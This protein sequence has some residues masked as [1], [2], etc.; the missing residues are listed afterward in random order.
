MRLFRT[1]SKNKVEILQVGDEP[2]D[3]IFECDLQHEYPINELYSNKKRSYHR[4]LKKL[5]LQDYLKN[6]EIL[7]DSTDEIFVCDLQYEYLIN[8]LYS[9]P[10]N[11]HT[12]AIKQILDDAKTPPKDYNPI[13]RKLYNLA[14]D[15]PTPKNLVHSSVKEIQKGAPELQQDKKLVNKYITRYGYKSYFSNVGCMNRL[16]I[17]T[18]P[19]SNDNIPL[20]DKVHG[21]YNTAALHDI[22]VKAL[23]LQICSR[24]KIDSASEFIY[25]TY[26]LETINGAISQRP[27]VDSRFN[28][29]TNRNPE[30]TESFWSADIPITP[31]GMELNVWPNNASPYNVCKPIRLK[32]KLWQF[33]LRSRI[34]CS[35][36]KLATQGSAFIWS[37]QRISP[38][39]RTLTIS[40]PPL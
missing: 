31:L 34:S 18:M 24:L 22:M 36:R 27:H 13:K 1:T 8:E 35:R 32:V 25:R 3:E 40:H 26:F 14:D 9:N 4:N 30:C 38:S 17:I 11:D 5:D 16:A 20:G 7:G 33:I 19:S 6:V 21:K 39:E 28:Y 29:S 15:V 37:L 12:I 23:K 10:K 2:T